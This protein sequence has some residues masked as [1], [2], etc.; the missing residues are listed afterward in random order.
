MA[1]ALEQYQTSMNSKPYEKPGVEPRTPLA[2]VT[3]AASA[4]GFSTI[5]AV[6]IEDYEG[7]WLSS[8]HGSVAQH[9][10]LKPEVSWVW[11]PAAAGLFTFLYFQHEGRC[12]EN[13][14][15]YGQHILHT[16]F[17]NAAS[18]AVLRKT[19]LCFTAQ[20]ASYSAWDG[21]R[22]GCYFGGNWSHVEMRW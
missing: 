15:H 5:C 8:C 6:H 17:H 12:S 2:W 21:L 19:A 11:L 3:L 1:V 13:I 22:G 9:W 4:D 16:W 18:I 14:N 10:Q 20:L 7:W